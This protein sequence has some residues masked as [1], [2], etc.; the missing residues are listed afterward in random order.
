MTARKTVSID[1]IKAQFNAMILNSTDDFKEGRAALTVA[2]EQILMD[3]KQYKGFDYLT[4]TDMLKSTHGTT[5]GIRENETDH[6]E[7]F[8]NVDH[9]RVR[10]S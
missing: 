6:K 3:A 8:K 10:Y 1:A 2:L 9:T 5:F 7:K 4:A